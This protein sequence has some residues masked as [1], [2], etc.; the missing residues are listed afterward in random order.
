MYTI[1]RQFCRRQFCRHGKKTG[2][3]IDGGLEFQKK[4][5]KNPF[6][7]FISFAYQSEI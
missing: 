6:I 5:E 7:S 1:H 4:K 2:D 3:R